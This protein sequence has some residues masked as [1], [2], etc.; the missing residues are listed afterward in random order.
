M[1]R[2]SIFGAR[3]SICWRAS[4][5]S[6]APARVVILNS[7]KSYIALS[8]GGFQPPATAAV[9]PCHASALCVPEMRAL[10]MFWVGGCRWNPYVGDP[11]SIL[12]TTTGAEPRAIKPRFVA[13]FRRLPVA[14]V[15]LC[16]CLIGLLRFGPRPAPGP[17][18]PPLSFANG[19]GRGAVST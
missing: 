5:V 15:V 19:W 10:P 2:L 7:S 8:L 16:G 14:L 17:F 18:L 12:M 9:R 6:L 13:E 11:G 3:S 1:L 4:L